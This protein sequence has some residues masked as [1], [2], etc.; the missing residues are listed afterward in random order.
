MDRLSRRGFLRLAGA[1]SAAAMLGSGCRELGGKG[2]TIRFWNGFTGPDGRTMLKIIRRFNAEHDDVQVTMQ[3]MDWGTYYNKLFVAAMS[4]RAPEVF[5]V[6]NDSLERFISAKL[7]APVNE[8][9]ELTGISRSD[10]D[11]NVMAE[12]KRGGI[13]YGLPLDC[14][15]AGCYYNRT[16]FRQCGVTSPPLTRDQFIDALRRLKKADD[17]HG[18]PQ[19]GFV[20]E[21]LRVNMYT[22]VRQWDGRIVADDRRTIIFDSPQVREAMDFGRSLIHELKLVPQVEYLDAFLG[23]RQ[24]RVG[25]VWA[26]IFKLQ[27]ATRSKDL[28][29]GGAII[30]TCGRQPGVW[31][32][33]HNLCLRRD[34][35]DRHKAAA[36]KLMKYLSDNTLDWAEGGQIPVRQSLRDTARFKSMA[37]QYEFA[38]QLPYVQYMPSTKFTFEYQTEF[39]TCSE[40]VLRAQTSTAQAVREAADNMKKAAAQFD[41]ELNA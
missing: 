32:A 12:S 31:A 38:K 3:R 35:D 37:V 7:L 10:I 39:D 4:G 36:Y 2:V 5:I 24:G 20:Y 29:F 19:W 40:R 16:L 17:G 23:F 33:S 6:H 41:D 30:P 27:D 34:L 28:D 22:L 26:G 11:A 8:V 14:H 15:P 9:Y 25:M 18:V 1:V 13:D 21:W